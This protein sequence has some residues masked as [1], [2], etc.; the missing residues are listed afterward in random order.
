MEFLSS[1]FRLTGIV[2]CTPF[3]SALSHASWDIVAHGINDFPDGTVCDTTDLRRSNDYINI[4]RNA[5]LKEWDYDSFWYWTENRVDP[6]DFADR[7]TNPIWGR[8]SVCPDN[9]NDHSCKNGTDW[10][11]VIF[12]FTHG[13]TTCSGIPWDESGT[14]DPSQCGEYSN[15]DTYSCNS[16]EA[17]SEFAMGDAT[18]DI[19]GYTMADLNRCR[20]DT[21]NH[22]KFGYGANVFITTACSSI[23][24]CTFVYGGYN[25]MRHSSGGFNTYLGFYGR[26][27]WDGTGDDLRKYIDRTK[28]NGIGSRWL[29]KMSTRDNCPMAIIFARDEDVAWRQFRWGGYRDFKDTKPYN[30]SFLYYLSGCDPNGKGEN[31]RPALPD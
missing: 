26:H 10:A 19:S 4:V 30:S 21:R 3:I 23:D 6:H 9:P 8:D 17:R 7:N 2:L 27:D 12:L 28:R 25:R 14:F 1:I 22:I 16:V 15:T 31:V 24:P 20:V 5:A 11:D 13:Y 18:P 29:E